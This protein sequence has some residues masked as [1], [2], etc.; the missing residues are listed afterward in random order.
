MQRSRLSILFIWGILT[1]SILTEVISGMARK[2]ESSQKH[3]KRNDQTNQENG[4]QENRQAREDS[5][6]DY[7][8]NTIDSSPGYAGNAYP[9]Y[10][11]YEGMV[12]IPI[13][14][15]LD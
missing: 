13:N 14:T 10:S 2:K 15:L 7:G 12:T 8:G 5:W 1:I 4:N 9:G 3:L 11:A 6:K